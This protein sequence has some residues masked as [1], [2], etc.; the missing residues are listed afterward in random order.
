MRPFKAVVWIGSSREELKAF[1]DAARNDA[2]Y[3]L[4]RVQCGLDPSDWKPMSRVGTGVK[5]IRVRATNGAFRVMYL[6]TPTTVFVLQRRT[7]RHS[8]ATPR[9]WIREEITANHRTG[10]LG[11]ATETQDDSGQGLPVMQVE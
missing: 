7:G 4:Y 9:R 2:G 10:H 8:G 5:E 6:A 1:P 3:E 11:S